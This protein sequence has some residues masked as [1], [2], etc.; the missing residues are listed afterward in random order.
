MVGHLRIPYTPA[1]QNC[2][3]GT[4]THCPLLPSLYFFVPCGEC[5]TGRA[6]ARHPRTTLS[7][8]LPTLYPTEAHCIVSTHS[9]LPSSPSSLLLK[10]T[11]KCPRTTLSPLLPTLY[12][13]NALPDS[14]FL[15]DIRPG[16]F[17][18][19]IGCRGT[20]VPPW[21]PLRLT[22]GGIWCSVTTCC[23]RSTWWSA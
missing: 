9:P 3:A 11:A 22:G 5:R 14:H 21:P 17:L 6:Q 8:L 19:A 20:S 23:A 10:P 18:V 12:S 7:P 15:C 13:I 4:T 2:R 1:R 16:L